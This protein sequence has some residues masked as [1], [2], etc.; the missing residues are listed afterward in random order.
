[1]HLQVY[2]RLL[3][4]VSPGS[5]W[6][7]EARPGR[8][9]EDSMRCRGIMPSSIGSAVRVSAGNSVNEVGRER[10]RNG[11]HKERPRRLLEGGDRAVGMG[12]CGLEMSEDLSGGQ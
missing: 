8:P 2:R 7:I 5:F 6:E 11:S 1:S 10:D 4:G 12:K 3:H 9:R